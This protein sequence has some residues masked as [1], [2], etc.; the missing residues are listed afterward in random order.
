MQV[1]DKEIAKKSTVCTAATVYRP[2]YLLFAK[3][4]INLHVQVVLMSTCEYCKESI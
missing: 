4:N 2:S 3:S 1:E